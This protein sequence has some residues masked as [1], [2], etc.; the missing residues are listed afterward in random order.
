LVAI[1][2]LVLT[3]PISVQEYYFP[4]IH[5]AVLISI[6]AALILVVESVFTKAAMSTLVAPHIHIAALTLIAFSVH[7]QTDVLPALKMAATILIAPMAFA[8][9]AWTTARRDPQVPILMRRAFLGLVTLNVLVA[10][11]QFSFG[12]AIVFETINATYFTWGFENTVRRAGL[13]GS[14]LDLGMLC[15]VA[16]PLLATIRNSSRRYLMALVLFLGCAVSQ[17]RT[18]LVVVGVATLILILSNGRRL[19]QNLASA[20]AIAAAGGGVAI[21]LGVFVGVSQRFSDQGY[22][23]NYRAQ[24]YRWFVANMDGFFITGLG[25]FRDP[26]EIGAT[27]SSL[28][29][30]YL[31][32]GYNFGVLFALLLLCIHFGYAVRV[33]SSVNQAKAVGGAVLVFI[34]MSAT[35][36]GIAASPQVALIIAI[37]AAGA[38]WTGRKESRVGGRTET[39]G[40]AD[41]PA[42]TLDR[43]LGVSNAQFRVRTRTRRPD[44]HAS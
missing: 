32:V 17:S 38:Q 15:A 8:L 10:T 3:V 34:L 24:A 1:Q 33:M 19:V 12:R 11:L 21:F 28:E 13:M 9:I 30:S 37:V 35:Y 14:P 7:S 43:S 36:S 31:A 26:R 27:T 40:R 44:E 18:A 39:W 41:M 22:S 6:F 16:S 5:P 25:P 4:G 20:A 42:Q 2:A 29:S 23:D